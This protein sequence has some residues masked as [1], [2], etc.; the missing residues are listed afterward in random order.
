MDPA[1]RACDS[2]IPFVATFDDPASPDDRESALKQRLIEIEN[3][4]KELRKLDAVED[5]IYP[6][7]HD[8][9][10]ENASDNPELF[11]QLASRR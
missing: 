1:D 10:D 7:L 2:N 9:L 11:E 8:W 4:A 6:R 5:F 3:I